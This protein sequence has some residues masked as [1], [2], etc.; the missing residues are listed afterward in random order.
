MWNETRLPR[1]PENSRTGIE[2]KP[3]VKYPVQTEAMA[4]HLTS[5]TMRCTGPC[6]AS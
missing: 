4:P 1:A 2:I 6:A 3:K 5:D